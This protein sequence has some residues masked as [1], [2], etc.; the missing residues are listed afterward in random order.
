M[1]PVPEAREDPPVN[2]VQLVHLDPQVP[3]V[4]MADLGKEA[5]EVQ[6]DPLDQQE[7][8]EKVVHLGQLGCKVHKDQEDHRVLKAKEENKAQ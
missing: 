8:Q 6:L 2:G 7:L 4:L 1:D 5:N 3:M